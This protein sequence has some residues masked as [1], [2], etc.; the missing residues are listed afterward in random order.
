MSGCYLNPN[1]RVG[2]VSCNLRESDMHRVGGQ[3]GWREDL[4][5]RV[6]VDKGARSAMLV[7]SNLG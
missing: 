4:A 6:G 5:P 2:L 3:W 7:I 1:P